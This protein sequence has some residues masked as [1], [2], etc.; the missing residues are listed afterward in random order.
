MKQL[1]LFFS[2]ACIGYS[3]F[4]QNYGL[5]QGLNYKYD[6]QKDI[7]NLRRQQQLDL[8]NQQYYE[9]RL[10]AAIAEQKEK[11]QACANQIRQLYPTLGK[12]PEQLK[13]GWYNVAVT[14][15]YD[16]CG[17][18]KV[19]VQ[20]NRVAKYFVENYSERTVSFSSPILEGKA[21]IKLLI[22]GSDTEIHDVYFLENIID[23]TTT[24]SKPSFGKYTFY[25][26]FKRAGT[27]KI[28]ID[29]SYAGTLSQYFDSKIGTPYCGQEG[30]GTVT[31]AYKPGT[32]NFIAESDKRKWSGQI[33]IN[34]DGCGMMNL[35]N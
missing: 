11:A 21:H 24:A 2:L 16:M 4:P 25:T 34:V 3:A 30:S 8:Q 32:F 28:F 14:N 12:Y 22:N 13:D 31:F 20:N 19:Y 9:S 6:Y 26:T 23:P 5:L 17:E 7:D 18:R 10:R 27:V 35:T 29:G 33:T 1:I 15:Y